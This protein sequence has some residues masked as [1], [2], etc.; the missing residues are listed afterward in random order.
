MK[1]M[2]MILYKIEFQNIKKNEF[3]EL[4]YSQ[5]NIIENTKKKEWESAVSC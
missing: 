5:E 1:K 4:L 3:N 2:C